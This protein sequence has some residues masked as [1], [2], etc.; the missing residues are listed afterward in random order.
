MRWPPDASESTQ[1]T[2]YERNVAMIS[3][4]FQFL[5]VFDGQESIVLGS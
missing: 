3:V 1:S 5:H 4:L 2:Q